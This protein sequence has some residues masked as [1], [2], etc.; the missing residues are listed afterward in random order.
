MRLTI[1]DTL[2][3]RPHSSLPIDVTLE[4]AV[5]YLQRDTCA[6]V[7]VSGSV[8][9]ILHNDPAALAALGDKASQAPYKAAPRAPVLYVK[10]RNTQIGHGAPIRVPEGVEALKM[11]PALGVV[12]GRTTC[13]VRQEDALAGVAGYTVVNDVTIAHDTFYRPSLPLRVRDDFCP[14]G[15][16]VRAARYITNPDDLAL[17]LEVDGEVIQRSTTKAFQR[18]LA[19]LIAEISDFM[20]LHPGDILIS[21]VPFAG[22]FD[23]PLARA[24]QRVRIEIENV[25]VLENTLVASSPATQGGKA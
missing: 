8:Y 22:S 15:P 16:W 4:R 14:I 19:Q 11:G 25:G 2:L 13:R 18:P 7:P 21:G 5:H 12:I 10:P 6:R 17:S 20:T 24:G 1:D 3:V 9:G 23:A